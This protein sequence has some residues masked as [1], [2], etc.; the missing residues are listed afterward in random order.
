MTVVCF[1]DSITAGQHAPAGSGWVELLGYVNAGVSGDTTRLGLERFPRDVQESGADWVLIQ[2]GHN[3]ANCWKTDRGLPRVSPSAYRANL[4]EMI[5]RARRFCIKPVL[6]G[7]T[8]PHRGALYVE[9]CRRYN[10]VAHEVA[11]ETLTPWI[12]MWAIPRRGVLDDGLHLNDDG[13]R[14]Y[15]DQVRDFFA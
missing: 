2:F 1:G 4:V 13:H 8:R 15:A 6:V 11:R 12:G 7:L 5:V 9:A 3:D 14:L 10:V